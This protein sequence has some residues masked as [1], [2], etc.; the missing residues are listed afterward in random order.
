[1]HGIRRKRWRPRR[2]Q[3]HRTGRE[4]S[5][6]TYIPTYLHTYTYTYTCCWH[7]LTQE[8]SNVMF[9]LL[10]CFNTP[11]GVSTSSLAPIPVSGEGLLGGFF[12][13][14][15]GSK[16]QDVPGLAYSGFEG[17]EGKGRE[18]GGGWRRLLASCM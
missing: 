14:V 7:V 8:P 16:M 2:K 15:C 10:H 11:C 5:A 18:E 13:A 3:P 6:D 12:H 17:L 1:M 9:R 4:A